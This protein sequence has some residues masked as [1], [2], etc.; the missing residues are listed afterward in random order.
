MNSQTP[1]HNEP[2]THTS[3]IAYTH[4][5]LIDFSFVL[6]ALGLRNALLSP[7]S[8]CAPL[9]LS[10]V[11]NPHIETRT[12][13]DER[14]AA[15]VALGMAQQTGQA[16]ALVCT[17]GTAAMNYGPALAEAFF[18]HIPLLV[19]T[20]DRPA[21]WIDQQDGQTVR[22]Q[23]LHTLHTK[24]SYQ[25]PA[26]YTH[27]D[28]PWYIQR[29]AAEAYHLATRSPAGPVHI[30]IPIRE[31]FYPTPH[32]HISLEPSVK[33]IREWEEVRLIGNPVLEKIENAVRSG[34]K[35]LWVSG[36]D[37]PCEPLQAQLAALP[38][39]VV[40]DVISNL[41]GEQGFITSQD[42]GLANLPPAQAEALRPDLL[43][44]WGGSVI[45]KNLKLFLRKY[46]P[47]AHWHVQEAG[48]VADTFQSLTDIVRASPLAFAEA[49]RAHAQGVAPTA[50]QHAW[51]SLDTHLHTA[52]RSALSD[53]TAD[54]W[55]E[56]ALVFQL[57]NALPEGTVLHLAN[58]MA[59]RYANFVGLPAQRGIEVRAN[60]GTS[61]IDG[62]VSTAVGHALASPDKLHV[63]LTGDL[64]LFYDRNAFWHIYAL[65]NLRVVLLNNHGGAIFKMIEGPAKLPEADAYFQTQ[66]PLDA[67]HLAMES[68]LP[69]YHSE[70]WDSF[71]EVLPR[72]FEPHAKAVVW[73]LSTS[74]EASVAAVHALKQQVTHARAQFYEASRL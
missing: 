71:E 5:P 43:I 60:R 50:F 14:S 66:Q 54:T 38:Y 1:P 65:P 16:V 2:A 44:T 10:M 25:L 45:S 35:I 48:A 52:I 69:Y 58:S 29:V 22:Q 37:A 24:G 68:Q 18:Q 3:Q 19:L 15:F 7:G 46:A 8:R 49:F 55:H 57:L 41:Q 74:A 72:L 39:P 42:L 30:N 64:S 62:S 70:H 6:S 63:L 61:G 31:P 53:K 20:A 59:V 40:T 47:R 12:F 11:R 17:S 26:D 27:P 13:S 32:T 56:P 51:Q 34:E 67:R 21:E 36:Q 23:G 33:V 4:Q 28:A 9:V 73:E